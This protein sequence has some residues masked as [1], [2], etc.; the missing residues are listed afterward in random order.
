MQCTPDL[1]TISW[2]TDS[3]KRLPTSELIDVKKGWTTAVFRKLQETEP[4]EVR[5]RIPLS[6][7]NLMH[8]PTHAHAPRCAP[9]PLPLSLVLAEFPTQEMKVLRAHR[10]FSL[11]FSDLELGMLGCNGAGW[12]E[13]R[14]IG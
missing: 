11:I 13:A 3:S 7:E 8:A 6:F 12:E 5:R 4:D 14:L 10:S 2:G 9:L 1:S